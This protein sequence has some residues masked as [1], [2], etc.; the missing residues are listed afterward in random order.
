MAQQTGQVHEQDKSFL[1]S[2]DSLNHPP[3]THS[4]HKTINGLF[5]YRHTNTS[6]H[7]QHVMLILTIVYVLSASI[8]LRSAGLQQSKNNLSAILVVNDTVTVDL[9]SCALVVVGFFCARIYN[10]CDKVTVSAQSSYVLLH[11]IIV[12]WLGAFV[13]MLCAIVYQP[14]QTVGIATWKSVLLTFFEAATA[15]RCLDFRQLATT[16]HNLN[17]TGWPTHAVFWGVFGLPHTLVLADYI[18][19][20]SQPN[21]PVLIMLAALLGITTLSVFA[22]LHGT[23]VFYANATNSFYRSMEFNVGVFFFYLCQEQKLFMQTM[24]DCIARL[25]S[26]VWAI[27]VIVWWV[28]IGKQPDFSKESCIRMYFFNSCLRDHAGFFIRGALLGLAAC[29][30]T[31]CDE[32]VVDDTQ[33]NESEEI[34]NESSSEVAATYRT[35]SPEVLYWPN[36]CAV[37]VSLCW[38]ISMCCEVVLT[39]TISSFHGH[40]A[41]LVVFTSVSSFVVSYLYLTHVQSVVVYYVCYVLQMLGINIAGVTDTLRTGFEGL[42]SGVC[43]KRDLEQEFGCDA[44]D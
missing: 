6:D 28:D 8:T 17:V 37:C 22:C 3:T 16:P 24:R 5:F 42:E 32:R 1:L 38:P 41:L 39:Y 14:W 35:V 2:H 43:D 7:L 13:S 4:I 29:L 44:Q 30:V 10:Q 18:K 31:G 34:G 36:F 33:C 26:F 20:I 19:R 25:Q 40:E 21:T 12:I 27:F 9:S 15:I 11:L 23:N